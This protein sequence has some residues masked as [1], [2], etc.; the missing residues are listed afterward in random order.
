VSHWPRKKSSVLSQL[1]A[2][3][4]DVNIA[5][6]VSFYYVF[7]TINSDCR[8]SAAKWQLTHD[9]GWGIRRF[10]PSVMPKPWPSWLIILAQRRQSGSKSGGRG[11]R[12]QKFSISSEKFQIF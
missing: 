2:E 8:D 9:I 10:L 6:Y 5:D 3:N 11:I 4:A 1:I 12:S 7:L